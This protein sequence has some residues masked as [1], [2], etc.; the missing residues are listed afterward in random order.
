MKRSVRLV[1]MGDAEVRLFQSW[2]AQLAAAE[3]PLDVWYEHMW[4]PDIDH[5]AIEGAPDDVGP[6]I[7][8]DAARAYLADWYEMF[9]DLAAVPEEIIDT[10]PER[11]IVVWR[12]GGTA[13][14]SGVPTELLVAIAYTIH[15][16][17]IVRGRE[18]MTK[19][20]ALAAVAKEVEGLPG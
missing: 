17:K 4:A 16:G 13:K 6:I 7:G 20:E 18:Y 9:P 8:R 11:V 19:D 12:I 1:T 14:A 15:G 2:V 5:R 10:G 3:D